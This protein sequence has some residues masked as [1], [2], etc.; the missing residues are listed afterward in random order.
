MQLCN[1]FRLVQPVSE[2]PKQMDSAD[3]TSEC[4]P[5]TVWHG[6]RWARQERWLVIAWFVRT[7]TAESSGQGF[8]NDALN[9]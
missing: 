3:F 5:M 6:E 9:S 7:S 1:T 4:A 2:P 8:Q